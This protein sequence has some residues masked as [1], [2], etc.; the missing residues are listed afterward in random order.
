MAKRRLHVD[1]TVDSEAIADLIIT[2]G[3]VELAKYSIY[4]RD[5]DLNKFFDDVDN[6]GWHV[7][8]QIRFNNDI[9]AQTVL[10]WVKDQYSN[11]LIKNNILKA[12]VTL[13]TCPHEQDEKSWSACIEDVIEVK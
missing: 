8:A 10:Q 1:L 2:N 13:H 5:T 7:V 12:R 3:K 4:F 6:T 11:S 9:D